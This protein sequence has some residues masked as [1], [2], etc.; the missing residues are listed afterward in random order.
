[1][2][3][4]VI[5]PTF[6]E[7]RTLPT[8]LER[9]QAVPVEKEIIIIDDGSTDGTYD[10]LRNKL[11][12]DNVIALR[13]PGNWGKSA[14]I[15]TGLGH[16]T[17]EAIIIQD[18]DLEYDPNEYP[19][20]LAPLLLGQT[21]V[22]YGSRMLS[23]SPISYRRYLYGGKFLT[24]LANRLYGLRITDEPTCY[25]LFKAEVLT[26]LPLA[27]ARFDFCPEVTAKL[28]RI[29]EKI[30]EVPVSYTPRRIPEGKKIRWW[31]GVQAIYV[32]FYYRFANRES[33]NA[34]FPYHPP[35]SEPELLTLRASG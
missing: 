9:V 1:M 19:Q 34:S 33:W 21:R 10:L 16:A 27:S 25:K 2:K 4:S 11:K 20:L 31:D 14:A 24:W 13:H 8:I 7:A 28:A 30:V 15:R 29:G 18:A 35:G 5:I 12:S 6:N 17:G 22:V 3:L 23:Q 32:L 26:D